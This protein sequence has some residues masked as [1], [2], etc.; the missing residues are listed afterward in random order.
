MT[1]ATGFAEVDVIAGGCASGLLNCV[2]SATFPMKFPV[3]WRI[4][5]EAPTGL[6]MTGALLT[7][8]PEGV[9]FRIVVVDPG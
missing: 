9:L 7:I 5:C 2:S 6:E 4:A 1:G 3:D 8:G